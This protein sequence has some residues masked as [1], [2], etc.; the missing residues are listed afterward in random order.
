MQPTLIDALSAWTAAQLSL[1]G[2]LFSGWQP[3][4]GDAGFRRYFRLE[5]L[6]YLAVYA[7]PESENSLLFC[8]IARFLRQ[9]GLAVPEII[10]ADF[11]QGFLLVSD[12]GNELY[13]AHLS[14]D[15]VDGLYGE[16][17]NT[18]LQLQVTQPPEGLLAHYDAAS[19]RRE[20]E[21]FPQWF[22][23][24]LLQYSLNA[25]EQQLLAQC[26]S[27]LEQAVAKQPKVVVHR[28]FH[29]RNLIYRHTQQG[30]LLPPGLIDFQDALIGPASYDLVS[31]LKDCYI[32]WPQSQ[33]RSFALAY[34]QQAQQLGI[35]PRLRDG[36]FIQGFDLMGL[37]RHIKVLGIFAR[38][39]LRDNKHGYLKD[40]PRVLAYTLDVLGHYP[41]LANVH[42]WFY[43]RLMPRI[44]QQ[45]WYY[46]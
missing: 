22:I 17:I 8:N 3:L 24:E 37:Q 25:D 42:Q 1:R 40:L 36:E 44:E 30:R 46:P 35:W 2:E 12:L 19:L 18:L 11:A 9:Q 13:A 23:G 31:L 6:P 43:L 5:K 16:A 34:Y 27:Y 28:D 21:L 10:G 15:R 20:M 39:S 45:S 29:S 33:V 41:A 14:E 7:P 4:A 38:L 26:F 32:D